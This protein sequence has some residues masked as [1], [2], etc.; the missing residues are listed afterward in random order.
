MTRC[1]KDF[2]PVNK[3]IFAFRSILRR[4]AVFEGR[5]VLPFMIL[6]CLYCNPL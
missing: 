6:F 3:V 4:E 1:Y 2:F 5:P